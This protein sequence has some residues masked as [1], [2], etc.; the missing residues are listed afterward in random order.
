MSNVT[1]GVVGLALC[2]AVLGAVGCS[3]MAPAPSPMAET[4]RGTLRLNRRARKHLRVLAHKAQ[5]D[6]QGRLVV[7]AFLQ[8]FTD[9][10]FRASVQVTFRGGAQPTASPIQK[11]TFP[12]GRRRLEWTSYSR[13]IDSYAIVISGTGWLPW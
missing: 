1:R 6:P 2:L 12:P 5:V 4:E 10:P 3:A 13:Q 8:N 7:T 9:D 11:V